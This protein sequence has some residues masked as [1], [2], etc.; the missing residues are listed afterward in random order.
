MSATRQKNLIERF[1]R[2][3]RDKELIGPD[4]KVLLAVSG[5]ADSVVMAHLFKEAGLQFGIAHCN[6]GLRG[7]ESDADAVFVKT[8]ASKFD[9][10]YF[11][12]RFDTEVFAKEHGLSIQMAAR[13]LRYRW[14]QETAE[15]GAYGRIATAHHR[16]D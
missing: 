3:I 2:F 7:N 16:N 5:G 14:F 10:P 4:E 13:T 9:V 8:L 1:Y 15:K 11:E 12:K 6:F